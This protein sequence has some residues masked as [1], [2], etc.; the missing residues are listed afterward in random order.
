MLV[1]KETFQTEET[2]QNRN[3]ACHG[4]YRETESLCTDE[5]GGIKGLIV[6]WQLKDTVTLAF[7]ISHTCCYIEYAM[8]GIIFETEEQIEDNFRDPGENW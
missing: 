5:A 6:Y 2:A 3:M 1:V 8:K 4:E 7:Q